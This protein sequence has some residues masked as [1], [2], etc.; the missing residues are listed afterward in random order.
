MMP[1]ILPRYFDCAARAA[2]AI[3]PLRAAKV[4]PIAYGA[5]CYIAMPLNT[6]ADAILAVTLRHAFHA[7][8]LMPMFFFA[9][10]MP[11]PAAATFRDVCRCHITPTLCLDAMRRCRCLMPYFDAP[12]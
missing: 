9:G 3:Q 11:A 7:V 12:L 8:A 2:N 6:A 1:L 10:L 5:R 4:F